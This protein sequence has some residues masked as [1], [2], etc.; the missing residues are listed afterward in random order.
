MFTC[1]SGFVEHGESVE[2]AAAREVLEETGVRCGSSALVASQPWPL[3]RGFHCELMLGCVAKAVEG[4]EEIDVT[5]EQGGGELEAARWF[6]RAEVLEMVERTGPDA[7]PWVPPSFAIAHH[8]I[9]R[10]ATNE[11]PARL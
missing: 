3:G 7:G 9:R 5:R 4:G 2:L 6:S 8:L 10:W 1:I 11:L